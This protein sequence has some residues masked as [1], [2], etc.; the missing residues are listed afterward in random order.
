MHSKNDFL[1][2]FPSFIFK[3]FVIKHFLQYNRFIW[4]NKCFPG[5]TYSNNEIPLI[6]L[7]CSIIQLDYCLALGYNLGSFLVMNVFPQTFYVKMKVDFSNET[8]DCILEDQAQAPN[9]PLP[10]HQVLQPICALAVKCQHNCMPVSL[11]HQG[12]K[13]VRMGALWLPFIRIKEDYKHSQIAVRFTELFN[14]E[15]S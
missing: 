10:Y 8:L 2:K 9:E 5:A 4:F 7:R 1:C 6:S 3:F 14:N 11:L 15:L 12:G 13:R